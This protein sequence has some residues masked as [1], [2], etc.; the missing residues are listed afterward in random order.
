M[1]HSDASVT[2]IMDSSRVLHMDKVAA[3]VYGIE[4]AA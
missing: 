4:R 1:K 2:N 3:F